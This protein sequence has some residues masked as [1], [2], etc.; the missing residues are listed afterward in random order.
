[1]RYLFLA[2]V[3]A[4]PTAVIAS[5]QQEY[6]YK[7]K[8][9]N[10]E[11]TFR[12][13]EGGKHIEIGNKIGPIEVMYRY[14]DLVNTQE[15]RIKFT[16]ELLSYKDLV[17]EGRMEYRHFNNKESHW[18]YRF[19]AEYTP[20]LYGPFYLYAKWQPRWSFKDSGTKFD[21]RDQLGITYKE[22]NWKVTPFIE[23]KSTEGYARKM[24]V[25]G[26]HWEA[27]I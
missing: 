9:K 15:N 10:W 17:F 18:R 23:R 7:L 5:D 14:A 22:K 13:R 1:M 19:I 26:I 2:L 25:T 8:N 6:N 3:L 11:Y 27:K 21:A 24:T 20:H 16:G 4:M 12:H